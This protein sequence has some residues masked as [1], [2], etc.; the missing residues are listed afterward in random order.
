MLLESMEAGTL[1]NLGEGPVMRKASRDLAM[2]ESSA[3]GEAQ[4]E[5]GGCGRRD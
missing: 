5:A 3:D 4:D 2:A 1:D